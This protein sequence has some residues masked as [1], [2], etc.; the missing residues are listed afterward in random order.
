MAAPPRRK[1]T[2]PIRKYRDWSSLP[3]ELLECIGKM[4]PSPREAAKFRSICP[5]WCAALPF[6]KYIAP[7]LMLPD[8][9]S[10]DGAINFYTP[11][12]G[13][14]SSFTRNLPSLR[15]KRLCGSSGGWL[16]LV[17]EAVSVTLLNP[18]TGATV[19]LPP[20]DERVVAASFRHV[21]TP[22][23]IPSAMLLMESGHYAFVRVDDMKK[24]AFRQIVLSSSSSPGS[25]E[26]VAMAALADSGTVAFCRVGVDR[27]WTL[28]ETNLPAGPV[29]SVVHFRGS[30]FLAISDGGRAGGPGGISICDVGGAVPTATR[31]QGLHAAPKLTTYARS[32]LQ[33]NGVLYVVATVSEDSTFLSHVYECNVM[34][35]EP[36]W[37]RVTNTTNNGL[38]FFMSTN[39][40]DFT[41]GYGGAPSV[42]TFKTNSV[43]CAKPA[44]RRRRHRRVELEIIDIAHGTSELVQPCDNTI[45]D[46]GPLCWIQPNHWA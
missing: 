30:T 6:A 8:P 42:S 3:E 1:S 37:T 27:A 21:M 7:V 12:D 31:I 11:G 13:G 25:G 16:A 33:V 24:R 40:S 14:E 32:H 9:D 44:L 19:E 45:H 5:A 39:L 20:A 10:P 46:S 41:A 4:L 22:D 23:G 17:D 34:A 28:L 15:G 36:R 35:A 38:T 43:Y 26:C 18:L 29:T 2:R